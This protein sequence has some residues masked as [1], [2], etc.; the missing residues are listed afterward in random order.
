MKILFY[1]MG[2][3]TYHDLLYYLRKAGHV[4]K[5]VYYHFPDKFKDPSFCERFSSYL[6][7]DHYDLVF[8]INF[9]PLVAQLCN[10]SHI[11]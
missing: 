3:Y 1:D 6:K 10:E 11:K 8:S 4:C 5:T 9:F 2:S 7:A